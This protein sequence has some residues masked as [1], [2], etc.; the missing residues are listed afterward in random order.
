VNP[1]IT[2]QDQSSI[3]YA[4]TTEKV[5]TFDDFVEWSTNWLKISTAG[6]TI[7]AMANTE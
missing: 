4:E 6:S 1:S 5:A 7:S 2:I 3:S